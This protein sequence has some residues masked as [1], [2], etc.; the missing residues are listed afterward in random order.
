MTSLRRTA[1]LSVLALVWAAVAGVLAP[2]AS[3]A[4]LAS[5]GT[6]HLLVMRV[7]WDASPPTSPTDTDAQSVLTDVQ[8]WFT[9]NSTIG[10]T[11]VLNLS[12]Q[13]TDWLGVSPPLGGCLTAQSDRD[14][15][16]AAAK[17]AAHDY[18]PDTY[19]DLV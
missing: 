16:L 4:P 14:A 9:G 8:N 12:L 10:G 18:N 13:L 6:Q 2:A 17:E 7:Y 11:P 19:Q 1:V 3:A 5:T 15:M